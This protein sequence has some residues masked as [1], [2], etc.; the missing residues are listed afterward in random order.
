MT[1]TT[2]DD[3]ISNFIHILPRY[4]EEFVDKKGNKFPAQLGVHIYVGSG[5]DGLYFVK[6]I[7]QMQLLHLIE[8]FVKVHKALLRD[9]DGRNG[10]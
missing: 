6:H 7:N 5:E 10:S 8:E 9:E 2:S 4:N 1:I 3:D